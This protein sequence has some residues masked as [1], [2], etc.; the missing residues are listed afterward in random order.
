MAEN[1][2]AV[3][4]VTYTEAGEGY[5]EKRKLRRHAAF[6]SLWALGV[7]A[8]ISGDFYGWNLGLDAGGFGGL[9]IAGI[10]ITIMYY[11]LCFS[12]AEMSPALPHTGGAYSFSRS[13]M[14]PWGGFITGLAENME[15]VI[16][17]A[18]VV[19]A[20]GFLSHDIVFDLTG[21]DGWWNSPVLWWAVYYIIFVGINILGI[22]ITMRFT[23]IIT[24]AALAVLAFFF[25]AVLVSGKFDA[26]LLTN[27][28]PD[29]GQSSFLPHGIAGIFPALPFAIWFYLAIEELPL[30]AEESHDPKRDIPRATIWGLTTLMFFAVGILF[31][32]T[33]IGGGAAAIGTSATPFFDGFKAVFGEGV[34]ASL[35]GLLALIGLIASFFTIIYAYGRNTYS[36]SRAGYFP[37]SSV[38]HPPDPQHAVRR[39]HRRRGD[40]LHPVAGHLFRRTER[41]RRRGQDR[42]RAAVHG[43]V[44][45]G[46]LVLHAVPGVHRAA[47]QAAEHRAAV[48]QPGR[49][50]GCRDR[51]CDRAGGSGVAVLQPRLSARCVRD[52]GLLRDRHHLLRGSRTAQ[53]G[54]VPEEEFAMSHGQHGANLQEEGY[55]TVSVT[56]ISA[57]DEPP[58]RSP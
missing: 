36:L 42:R 14:G 43:G 29:E 35:L 30:A 6:W 54:A 33:G 24:V 50:L 28:P 34:G 44:R 31:L 15:Y 32:N 52:A 9:L 27:I 18:V 13:A 48:P 23:V 22:E 39:A 47:P 45:R 16:T 57:A 25:V 8:V 2:R 53:A 40:R 19:G 1:T 21:A 4:S 56:E 10:V 3:G 11:G 5:F 26:S 41:E 46:D 49:C 58:T 17:P 20:M 38:D 12:I 55:G 51:G 7:G 37:Q